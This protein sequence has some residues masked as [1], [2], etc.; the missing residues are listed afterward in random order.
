[1]T[2]LNQVQTYL[3]R[4]P[5]QKRVRVATGEAIQIGSGCDGHFGQGKSSVDHIEDETALFTEL[6]VR[7]LV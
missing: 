6:K 2:T 4:R 1:M 5:R 7:Y 3:L